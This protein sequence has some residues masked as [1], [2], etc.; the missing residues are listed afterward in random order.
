MKYGTEFKS[1]RVYN[2]SEIT[3]SIAR[4]FE[5]FYES[6]Y[7]IK[8]EISALNLYPVS[9]HC[10]PLMVEKSEGKVKAQLKATIWKEDLFY[11]TQKFEQVTGEIFREGLEIMFL[12]YVKFSSQY[13]L[14]LQIV[15]IEPL[16]TLGEMAREKMKTIELLKS[17][18]SFI[19]NREL[20][21]PLFFKRIAIISVE[22]SKGYN[23][24]MVTL[25]NNPQGYV[26]NTT[27][28]PAVLQGR[29]A[30][31]TMTAR[32]NEISR[33]THLFDG[34]VI[35]RGGG[36]DVGLSC[37]DNIQLARAVALFPLP[38]ITGIGHSTNETVTEM[39][40]SVNKITPTDVAHFIL[41]GF[42]EADKQLLDIFNSLRDYSTNILTESSRRVADFRSEIEALSEWLLKEYKSSV[43]ILGEKLRPQVR[44]RVLNTEITLNRLMQSIA[45]GSFKKIL[46]MNTELQNSGNRLRSSGNQ[47]L[48]LHRNKLNEHDQ[49]IQLID[50]ASVLKRGY[51]ILR[52]NGKLLSES[53]MA[54]KGNELEVETYQYIVKGT[55]SQIS[56]KDEHAGS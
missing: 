39:V 36:D 16:Y 42:Y 17:D 41:A 29:G 22:S 35:V 56:E 19:R 14:S 2:L 44:Q 11:I 55:I 10:F 27:L 37:Y 43:L 52:V 34:V 24:L 12:A 30:V 20:E 21:L 23:D 50:P 28:F 49:H 46:A 48:F 40:A 51:S 1:K 33:Q 18:G 7:W 13:G 3:E 4:M 31:E 15:D 5:K 6:P 32:L 53:N 25:R 26:V 47:Y 9:G 38:V 54:I 8:A 45:Y